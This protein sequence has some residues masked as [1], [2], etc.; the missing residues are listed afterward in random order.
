MAF[1]TKPFPIKS[2]FLTFAL[3][4]H[5][6]LSA[7]PPA[8]FSIKCVSVTGI[9]FPSHSG[10]DSNSAGALCQHVLHTYCKGFSW[11]GFFLGWKRVPGSNRRPLPEQNEWRATPGVSATVLNFLWSSPY[12]PVNSC[13]RTD[14]Q[15]LEQQKLCPHSSWT[16]SVLK[17]DPT[18]LSTDL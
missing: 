6:V 4:H 16:G 15:G 11:Q 1:V 3:S 18:F 13:R 17:T 7:D 12:L 8:P 5:T 9:L 2:P 10:F 14:T